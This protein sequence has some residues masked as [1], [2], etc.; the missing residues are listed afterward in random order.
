MHLFSLLFRRGH[1]KQASRPRSKAKA[2][3]RQV[4]FEQFENRYLLAAAVDDTF[5]GAMNTSIGGDPLSNDS[6]NAS[7]DDPDNPVWGC[8]EW[9]AFPGDGF[10]TCI[11]EG[12]IASTAYATASATSQ[13][14]NGH[15]DGITYIP[16][17]NF[18]G[19]DSFNYTV[20]DN[21]G[22]GYATITV[23]VDDNNN[24]WIDPIF[25]PSPISE[26]SPIQFVSLT[27]ILTK[28]WYTAI[29]ATS[30]NPGLIPDPTIEYDS[31]DST[32]SLSFEPM[33]YQSGT[34]TI[35]IDV[36]NTGPDGGWGN[37]DDLEFFRTFTVTVLPVNDP[38]T[39]DEIADPV[40]ILEDTPAQIINLNG[41]SP[42]PTESQHMLITA[43][44]SNPSLIPDLTVDYDSVNPSAP[45]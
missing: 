30:N 13:P 5:S 41:I 23:I 42:G 26:N 37:G 28:G 8:V 35:T 10:Y 31:P 17:T 4:I 22:C 29:T 32:G 2:R 36:R 12:W 14:A 34:A 15:L 7:W 40:P 18:V 39:F 6:Y 16:D 33:A 19:T 11:E 25:D 27:G 38:P 24:P 45:S 9:E 21:D 3:F 20:C 1:R 43:I 44:S